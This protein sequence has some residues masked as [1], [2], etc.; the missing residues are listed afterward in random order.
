[1][2]GWGRRHGILVI[3][4]TLALVTG[5]GVALAS[6]TS[7]G[8]LPSPSGGVVRS[9][10][11]QS[12]TSTSFVDLTGAQVPGSVAGDIGTG[13]TV[14]IV[15]FTA[16]STCTGPTTGR[17]RVRVLVG[18]QEGEPASGLDF[19]FDSASTSARPSGHAMERSLCFAHDGATHDAT[20]QVQFAVSDS[21][22]SFRLDDWHL[23][24]GRQ[25]TGT[26]GCT[27]V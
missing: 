26:N 14:V 17:C 4:V 15:T 9:T 11:Q 20:V 22:V 6:T 24:V 18:S 5:I 16:E 3:A 12:T 23:R 10:D 8:I 21:A 7:V 1:M 19:A 2:R 27:G 25:D 13:S